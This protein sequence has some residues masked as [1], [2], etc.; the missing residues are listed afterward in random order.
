METLPEVGPLSG[1]I[2]S[3]PFLDSGFSAPGVVLLVSS[4][5]GVV[6][7]LQIRIRACWAVAVATIW[8]AVSILAVT[9]VALLAVSLPLSLSLRAAHA[10]CACPA[11]IALSV[12]SALTHHLPSA[13]ATATSAL[14][15]AGHRVVAGSVTRTSCLRE[16]LLSIL[17]WR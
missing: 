5:Q 3:R 17:W 6:V 7:F 10:R 1:F 11:G 4:V 16:R 15:T 12:F 8:I 9:A 14:A 2:Q 13:H